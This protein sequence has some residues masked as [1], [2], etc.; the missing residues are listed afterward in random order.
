MVSCY[1][2]GQYFGQIDKLHP[3]IPSSLCARIRPYLNYDDSDKDSKVSNIKQVLIHFTS[4]S[5]FLGMS[6]S[7]LIVVFGAAAVMSQLQPAPMLI[8]VALIVMY[9]VISSLQA[10]QLLSLSY[11]N[12]GSF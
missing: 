10:P 7:S 6:T 12:K 2:I 1:P 9:N 3:M 8:E 4:I 5:Y 11:Q